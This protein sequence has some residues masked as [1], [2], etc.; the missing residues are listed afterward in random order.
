MPLP[1]QSARDRA[2]D[3]DDQA[4]VRL[5]LAQDA[6]ALRTIM[7]RHN[8]RLYRLARSILI[9]DTEAEDVLQEAYMR[10]FA[11]LAGFRGE[12]TLATWLSRIVINEAIARLRKKRR[13]PTVP[14]PQRGMQAVE[15]IAF[16]YTTGPVDPERQMAQRQILELVEKATDSLPQDFRAVFM[17]RA[18]QGLSVEETAELLDLK[19]ETVK[20]RLFRA[21]KLLREQLETQVGEVLAEA[22]PF[23]GER[24]AG[25]TEK[26]MRR[27]GLSSDRAGA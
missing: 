15:L 26:V 12:A 19:P 8:Q 18:I 24:C 27:L 22:F 5:A 25:V 23:A 10:A 13:F 1:K 9:D 16:P 3:L 14:P 4:M 21:R 7:T 11:G 2:G 6:D 17:A 20:T